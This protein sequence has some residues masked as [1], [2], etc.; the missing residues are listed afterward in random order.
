MNEVVESEKQ[1]IVFD[2]EKKV[3]DVK[4]LA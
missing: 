2:L 1:D 4:I 3:D